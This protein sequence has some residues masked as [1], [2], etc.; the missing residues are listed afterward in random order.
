MWPQKWNASASSGRQAAATAPPAAV[1]S[2]K[3]PIRA[4]KPRREARCAS[5]SLRLA[6][7]SGANGLPR[8]PLR[9]RDDALQLRERVERP[10]REH[11]PVDAERHGIGAAG[12]VERAPGVRVALLVE[13]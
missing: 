11:G 9:R 13:A 3:P 10:L 5:A 8:A 2:R 4:R 6:A 1:A 7:A 12:D